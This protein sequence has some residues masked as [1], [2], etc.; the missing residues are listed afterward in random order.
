M[1]HA[2]TYSNRFIKIRRAHD[3]RITSTCLLFPAVLYDEPIDEP[4]RNNRF[5]PSLAHL[6]NLAYKYLGIHLDMALTLNDHI[7]KI[8]KKASS[9]LGLLHRI[10]PILT[11]HA[12]VDLCKAMVQPVMTYCSIVL[13]T[14]SETNETT[15]RKIGKR[16]L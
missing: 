4:I 2:R 6:I 8:C 15:F 10:R 12:A 11:T 3:G 16:A 13:A 5:D 1:N 7:Q 9:R 14:L